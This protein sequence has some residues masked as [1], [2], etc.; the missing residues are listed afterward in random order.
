MHAVF[1]AASESP[2]QVARQVNSFGWFRSEPADRG[3]Q[4]VRKAAP[5]ARVVLEI[6]AGQPEVRR[7]FEAA[8]DRHLPVQRRGGKTTPLVPEFPVMACVVVEQVP[9]GKPEQR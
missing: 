5:C 4:D 2:R 3:P 8:S 6:P 9:P 7:A 1:F